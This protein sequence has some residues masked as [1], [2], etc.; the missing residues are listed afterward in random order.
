MAKSD[1]IRFSKSV[2]SYL[3]LFIIGVLVLIVIVG[4]VIA[5][6]FISSVTEPKD[7]ESTEMIEV[8]IDSGAGGSEIGEILE[9]EGI[10]DN[11]TMF[12]IYLMLNSISEYQAGDYELSPSM[13]F[14]QIARTLETGTVYQE[15]LYRVTIPEGYSIEQIAEQ[16]EQDA[17]VSESRFLEL[18]EDEEFIEEVIEEYPE[19]LS[20]E[21]LDEDVKYPLEG[22]LY[23]A[24]YDI[25]EEEPSVENIVKQML[26]A[27]QSNSFQEYNDVEDY[28]INLEGEEE[29][30]SFHE[31]LTFASMIEMEATSLADRS[32][33][34]SV[35]YNRLESDPMMPL[36]TDPTVLYALGEHQE[37]TLFEDLEVED[38]YNTYLNAGLP[39][40]PIS[41]PG[42][43]SIQST[44]NPSDTDYFYFLAD[45][46]GN[47]HYA[48]T[49]EE[50]TENR[51]EYI[52][53]EEEE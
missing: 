46:E 52:N 47:N 16:L 26:D 53:N 38:P 15:V 41:S 1:D 23:P 31:F 8:S 28:E 37:R 12:N 5:Y 30:Q 44:L 51:E 39:P 19:M 25:T 11:G 35:F 18:M 17:P 32:M 7:E 9:N 50:H 36:Q 21:I 22:Y 42:S 45:S 4:G 34:A 40:G 43:E 10:I 33:I 20:D 49:F 27:T 48:E 14:E 13:N 6:F 24:T 3:S 29:S 2:S